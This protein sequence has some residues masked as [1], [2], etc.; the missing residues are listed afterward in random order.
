MVYYCYNAFF[1]QVSNVLF[2]FCPDSKDY[3]RKYIIN[4][5]PISNIT[6]WC[7]SYNTLHV[8]L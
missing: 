8:N 1:I 5:V 4:N 7:H 2:A 3:N 6:R